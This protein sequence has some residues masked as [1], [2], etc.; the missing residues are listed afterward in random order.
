MIAVDEDALDCDLAETYQIYDKRS[1]PVDRVATF[2]CG[3]GPNSRI[4]LKI[5]GMNY[6]LET[7]LLASAVDR[8]SLLV[9]AKSKNASKGIKKPESIVESL[10][11][12]QTNK[13]F[14]VFDSA[15]DFEKARQSFYTEREE[16]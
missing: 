12:K 7:I 13:D 9:W 2:S 3:L 6:P 11:P 16:E 4:K 5:S 8:L 1:L 10:M 14:D 15:E